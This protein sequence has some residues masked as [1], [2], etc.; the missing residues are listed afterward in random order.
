M[1]VV[2]FDANVFHDPYFV[3]C[4][5]ILEQLVL[6]VRY[7]KTDSNMKRIGEGERDTK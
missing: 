5:H 6:C 4:R 3:I 1:N 2:F 7:S